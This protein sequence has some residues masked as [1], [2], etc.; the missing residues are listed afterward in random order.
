MYK[1]GISSKSNVF[2]DEL[3][4]SYARAGISTVEVSN[5][6]EGYDAIDFYKIKELS[7]EYGI[8]LNSLH[9]PFKVHGGRAHDISNPDSYKEA[10]ENHKALIRRGTEI[11][12]K[13]F[14]L[15]PSSGK[16]L[17]GA[18]DVC[19][20]ICKKSL[21]ELAEYADEQGAVIALENMTHE[22]LGNTI[23]E[24]EELVF[25]H[26]KLRVCF[27]TNHL[28]NECPGEF[29][30]RLGKRIV[31]MHVSDCNLDVEQHKMPGEGKVNFPKILQ[32]LSEVGY[33][34]PWLYEVSY[35]CPRPANDRYGLTCESFVKNAAELFA[36]KIPI[37]ERDISI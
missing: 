14:V 17:S 10:I 33:S 30:K 19:K 6:S 11:G 21:A 25:S 5:C 34:G 7:D 24:F 31:T 18:R 37:V 3:F 16:R 36:G 4:S 12:I 9:L 27:D 22:C 28:L 29:I 15:H 23:D 13:V 32:A 2:S 26:P 20:E 35:K 1:I 8:T